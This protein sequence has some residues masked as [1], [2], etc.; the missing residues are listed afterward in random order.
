[1]GKSLLAYSHLSP[2]ENVV[3]CLSKCL[4]CKF[5]TA[6]LQHEI[7]AAATGRH[8]AS[9]AFSFTN[10]L[11]LGSDHTCQQLWDNFCV[12]CLELTPSTA[13]SFQNHIDQGSVV[14]IL[15]TPLLSARF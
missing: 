7:E 11:L 1:M 2:F 13:S 12:K 5:V 6:V 4:L 3:T 9:I 14:S 10:L 15:F 8:S